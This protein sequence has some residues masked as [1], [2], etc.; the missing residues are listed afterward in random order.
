MFKL[1]STEAKP[2]MSAF[3][4]KTDS[5]SFQFTNL[6]IGKEDEMNGSQYFTRI[7]ENGEFRERRTEYRCKFC[8]EKFPTRGRYL[9]HNHNKINRREPYF[10]VYMFASGINTERRN[11]PQ[12]VNGNPI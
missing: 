7:G 3:D 8:S 5:I 11:N 1:Q 4:F 10:I 9:C 6:S 12:D 2:S